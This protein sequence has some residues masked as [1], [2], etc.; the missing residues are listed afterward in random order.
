[1]SFDPYFSS[2]SLLLHCNGSNGSTTF[3]DSSVNACTS[4]VTG[5][6]AISTGAYAPLAGNTSSLHCDGTGDSLAITSGATGLTIGTGDFT[7]EFW[8]QRSATPAAD[9]YLFDN[10]H[11]DT[12]G[13]ITILLTTNN[14]IVFCSDGAVPIVTSTTA[15]TVDTMYNV[16][17][18]RSGTN[19]KLFINGTQEGG[20]ITNS[21]NLTIGSS[22]NPL[23]IS[24]NGVTLDASNL[25]GYLDE[26]RI[27]KGVARYTSNYTPS[28]VAFPNNG[29]Q[30]DKDKLFIQ[31]K[32]IKSSNRPFHFIGL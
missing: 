12:P 5:N 26:I 13:S 15:L 21:T 30:P 24:K 19:L 14:K 10:R 11:G 23:K 2:V 25:N 32:R 16:S 27:T 4:S 7:F 20:T 18:T 9:W 28:A 22:G 3:T 31:P 8:I 6:A 29:P 1:M 17:V